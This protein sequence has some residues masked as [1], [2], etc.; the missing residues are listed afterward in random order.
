[1]T[2]LIDTSFL[3]ALSVPG[4]KHHQKAVDLLSSSRELRIVPE[5]VLPELFYVAAIRAGYQQ[6]TK[7]IQ[8][9]RMSGLRRVALTD[10]D[11]VRVEAIMAK[12]ADARFDFVDMVIMALAERLDIR[13]VFTFDHRDFRI[14]RPK[15]C[16]YLEIKP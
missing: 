8:T 1:M 11:L 9:V 13:T 2:A 15:H 6:A 5:V 16:P 3:V 12:Y 14:F 10:A 4:D 7:A